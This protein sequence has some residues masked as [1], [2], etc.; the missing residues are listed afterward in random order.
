MIVLDTHIWI[1]WV[2][3]DPRLPQAVG[4]YLQREEAQG[5][6]VSS[7]SCWE[8][9]MLHARGRLQLPLPCL[10]WLLAALGTRVIQLLQ[11]EPAVA[12]DSANLP[13][14]F[15]RDPADQI[16]VATARVLQCSLVT[17][18]ARIRAYPH[19]QFGP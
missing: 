9:A 5:L 14:Q 4:D 2:H 7:I 16:I 12:V 11:I 1:W 8:V 19:V 15:H 18:D 3:D 10:D 13:G 6:G 17:L